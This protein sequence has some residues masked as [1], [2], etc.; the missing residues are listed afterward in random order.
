MKACL[1]AL[2]PLLGGCLSTA[3][4]DAIKAAERRP[5]LETPSRV[6]ALVRVACL[7]G[8]IFVDARYGN[9]E[10]LRFRVPPSA[11]PSRFV[12][13]SAA[14]SFPPPEYEIPVHHDGHAVPECAILS[15]GTLEIRRGTQLTRVACFPLIGKTRYGSPNGGPYAKGMLRLALPLALV[16]DVVL[17]SG[18]LLGVLAGWAGWTGFG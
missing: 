10:T 12:K 15:A 1:F 7:E 11:R 3:V 18:L 5:A 17:V 8:T 6:T 14:E 2:I 9:G 13:V 16:L 4:S